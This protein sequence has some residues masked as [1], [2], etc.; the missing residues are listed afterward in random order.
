M[1][2]LIN[3]LFLIFFSHRSTPNSTTGRSPC[4]LM[5]KLPIRTVLDLLKPNSESNVL[6]KQT[7]EKENHDSTSCSRCFCVDQPVT[8]YTVIVTAS[9]SGS[10]G[11]HLK[12]KEI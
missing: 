11:S 5:L 10:L 12:R 8:W 7:T 9:L 1:V 4:E 6:N 2:F 3:I